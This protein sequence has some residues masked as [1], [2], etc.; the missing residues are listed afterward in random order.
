MKIKKNGIFFVHRTTTLDW[1]RYKQQQMIWVVLQF[2]LTLSFTKTTTT[3]KDRNNR[4]NNCN[5]SVEIAV[6]HQLNSASGGVF[7]H[8][9][10]THTRT[11]HTRHS[12]QLIVRNG[13]KLW[14][15]QFFFSVYHPN[16]TR[17]ERKRRGKKKSIR[18]THNMSCSGQTC[19]CPLSIQHYRAHNSALY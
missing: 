7:W 1:Y 18:A 19:R 14:S 15:N 16:C 11:P 17:K 2:T 4:I 13:R 10:H 12:I 9:A 3:K 8:I 6:F 5:D